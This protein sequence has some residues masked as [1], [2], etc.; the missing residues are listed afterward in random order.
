MA[1]SKPEGKKREPL[2]RLRGY[3]GREGLVGHLLKGPKHPEAA[4]L[5]PVPARV[6][7]VLRQLSA[8]S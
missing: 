3:G 2:L 8:F 4:P 1:C 5:V 7:D 6:K